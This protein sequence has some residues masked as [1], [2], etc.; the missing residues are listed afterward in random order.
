MGACASVPKAMRDEA[1]AVAPPPEQPKE[2]TPATEATAETVVQEVG[3][4]D[5]KEEKAAEENDQ[6]QSLG[7][8]LVE[9]TSCF[10]YC[11]SCFISYSTI[12]NTQY[13]RIDSVILYSVV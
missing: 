13:L 1:T 6:S 8:L 10:F 11:K 3:G 4:D 5:K 9:V 2:E 12:F 7:T